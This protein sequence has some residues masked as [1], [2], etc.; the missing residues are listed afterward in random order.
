MPNYNNIELQIKYFGYQK[1]KLLRVAH[2]IRA[3]ISSYRKHSLE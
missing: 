3:N 1:S 2:N